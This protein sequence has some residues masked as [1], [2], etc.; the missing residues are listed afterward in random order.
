MDFFIFLGLVVKAFITGFSFWFYWMDE[1]IYWSA[2]Q[3]QSI[4]GADLEVRTQQYGGERIFHIKGSI[5]FIK[6]FSIGNFVVL[7]DPRMNIQY[8]L[9]VCLWNYTFRLFIGTV[10]RNLIKSSSCRKFKVF[11]DIFLVR[12]GLK[13]GGFSAI[14]S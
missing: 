14:L 2:A 13:R 12:K 10:S 11:W 6:K 4:S 3:T 9:S 8:S 5:L 1:H 7:P